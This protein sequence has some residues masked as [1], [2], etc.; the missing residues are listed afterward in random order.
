MCL[1]RLILR[2]RMCLRRW[3]CQRRKRPSKRAV[4][5]VHHWVRGRCYYCLA[6]LGAVEKRKNRWEVEHLVS[7][8]RGGDDDLTNLTASCFSCNKRKGARS[9]LA[10]FHLLGIR[11]RCRFVDLHQNR[12]CMADSWHAHSLYCWRHFF[13]I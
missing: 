6:S 13:S 3:N 9:P 11:P 5:T 12:M 2:L 8:S 1:S 4:S 7:W 10:M